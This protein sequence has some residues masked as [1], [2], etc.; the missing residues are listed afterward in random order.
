MVMLRHDGCVMGVP[1]S[2]RDIGVHGEGEVHATYEDGDRL[3]LDAFKY[4]D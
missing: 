1:H 3:S 4:E 2:M